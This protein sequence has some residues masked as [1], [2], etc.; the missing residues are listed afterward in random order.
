MACQQ[1][2]GA[3]FSDLNG[4]QPE[5]GASNLSIL[6]RDYMKAAGVTEPGSM[7]RHT[8]AT[9]MLENGAHIRSL[10]QLLG[11][12]E[13]TTTQIYTHVCIKQLQEIHSKTHPADLPPKTSG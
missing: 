1:R 5:L 3:A 2:G 11:H 7:L 9:Q 8:A 12:S 10:Q 6:V 13:L 4:L